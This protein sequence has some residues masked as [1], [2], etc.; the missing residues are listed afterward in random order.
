MPGWA[1]P[2]Q[3]ARSSIFT[4]RGS[5]GRCS[6]TMDV[7]V[8]HTALLFVER[9]EEKRTWGRVDLMSRK[10]NRYAKQL[11]LVGKLASERRLSQVN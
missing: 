3:T 11:N 5:A 9:Y 7:W 2:S 10:R 4:R 6:V 8:I 1:G